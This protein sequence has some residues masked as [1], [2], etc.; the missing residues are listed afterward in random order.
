MTTAATTTF[1]APL[2]APP[3]KVLPE[4]IDYNGHMNVAFYVMAFD[5][6]V[7]YYLSMI[8]IG[9][10]YI[11]SGAGTTFT[12][13]SN[14]RYLQEVKEGDP[15]RITLQ[16]LDFDEKRSHYFM[17]MYHATENFLAA[18]GEQLN[19]HISFPERKSAPMPADALEKL[20][21]LMQGHSQL[22]APDGVGAALGIRRR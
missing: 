2:V 16:L 19:M 3:L 22:P 20:T 15:L 6:C 5:Q 1:P 14:V 8:G 11:R 4:W 13:Q 7:D 18:T 12:L 21:L 9:E 10:A 17:Q